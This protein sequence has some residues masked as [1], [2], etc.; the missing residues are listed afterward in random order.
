MSDW[1]RVEAEAAAIIGGRPL[2]Y[3]GATRQNLA[4]LI[5]LIRATGRP[6]PLLSPGYWP[7]FCATWEIEGSKTLEIEVFDDRYEIYR[8]FDGKTDISHEYHK[9]GEPMSSA[10]LRELPNPIDGA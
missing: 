3:D 1:E 10:F 5:R 6:P 9:P 2:Q 8:F 7:T 4:E